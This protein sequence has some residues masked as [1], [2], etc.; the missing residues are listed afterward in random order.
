MPCDAIQKN[1]K[2]LYIC[3][4]RC[5]LVVMK[6]LVVFDEETSVWSITV[7]RQQFHPK[8]H[9]YCIYLSHMSLRRNKKNVYKV[10]DAC[11]IDINECLTQ[12]GVCENGRCYN[13]VGGFRCDCY[14]GYRPSEDR[15]QCYGKSLPLIVI[16]LTC[17]I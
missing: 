8:S 1:R 12:S 3:A 16:A 13:L 9:F 4:G 5:R 11:F 6:I 10:F 2:T 15:K 17:Q 7:C 14:P